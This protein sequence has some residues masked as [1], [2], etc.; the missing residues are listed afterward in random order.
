VVATEDPALRI[1]HEFIAEL[2]NTIPELRAQATREIV[3]EQLRRRFNVTV[4]VH[5][6]TAGRLYLAGLVNFCGRQRDGLRALVDEL[7]FLRLITPESSELWTLSE[8]WNAVQEFSGANWNELRTALKAFDRVSPTTS[9]SGIWLRRL[10]SEATQGRVVE[11]PEHC[12]TPWQVFL[13]LAGWNAAADG[14]PPSMKF[15]HRL[16]AQLADDRLTRA[17]AT[18]NCHWTAE[19]GL[20]EAMA[21]IA[22]REA[23]APEGTGPPDE[24]FAYLLVRIERDL[25]EPEKL[26]VSH[27]RQWDS[28][29]WLP[30]DDL[31]VLPA[32]LEETVDG[33]ISDMESVLG[34]R[35]DA[36]RTSAIWLEFV[37]PFELFHLPVELWSKSPL[38]GL[39]IPLA[40]DHPIVIRSL[41]RWRGRHLHRNWHRRWETMV[42]E[43][44]RPYWSRPSGSD[45]VTRLAAALTDERIVS[46]VLSE[47][48]DPRNQTAYNEIGVALHA[49]LPAV[50]WH[51][52]DCSVQRFRDDVDALLGDGRLRELPRRIAALRRRDI[53]SA[54][55]GPS[56]AA[57]LG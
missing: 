56:T 42:T 28:R 29:N 32:R 40:V 27:W 9:P 21:A 52:Q 24:S 11:L 31:K 22:A 34:A 39:R 36:S 15:L 54:E 23:T 50:L 19:F 20:T 18:W 2:D 4:A 7:H 25:D 48:P 41:D 45:Y 33:L 1:H 5:S 3:E 35:P 37:L 16:A 49:G 14:L 55:T 8:E 17:V 47:P 30:G 6:Q 13:H 12:R 26:L 10:A 57:A 51:R 43:Q 53:A 44:G 46:L 38:P